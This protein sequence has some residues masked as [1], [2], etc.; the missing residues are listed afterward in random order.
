MDKDEI[1]KWLEQKGTRRNIEGM[2]RYGIHRLVF[3]SSLE[4]VSGP[5]PSSPIFIDRENLKT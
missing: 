4:M 1:L 5:P 3:P 2:A